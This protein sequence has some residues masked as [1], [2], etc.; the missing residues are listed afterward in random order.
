MVQQMSLG[1]DFVL[2]NLQGLAIC[3]AL[4]KDLDY[5]K[6]ESR[7]FGRI[8]GDVNELILGHN[9]RS[10][11]FA[12]GICILHAP[13]NKFDE[14]LCDRLMELME[15]LP[16]LRWVDDSASSK[17][18]KV[19][20]YE[21][22][23]FCLNTILGD[24]AA[25][26]FGL[27]DRIIDHQLTLLEELVEDITEF[28]DGIQRSPSLNQSRFNRRLSSEVDCMRVIS[29]IFGLVR[30][31]GRF[32]GDPKAPLISNIYPPPFKIQSEDDQNGGK[33]KNVTLSTDATNWFWNEEKES[34]KGGS[35]KVFS[36]H[37][38]SFLTPNVGDNDK[39]VLRLMFPEIERLTVQLKTLMDQKLLNTLDRYAEDVFHNQK[40]KRFPYK[41]VSETITLVSVTCL[42][43]VLQLYEM[44]HPD[45]PIPM[46]YAK[47]LYTF[48]A[49]QFAQ[50]Q[51]QLKMKN[52]NEDIREIR[53]SVDDEMTQPMVNRLK[54]LII[55]N[56]L[57]I[58]LIVWS[59]IDEN[60]GYL[61]CNNIQDKLWQP[62]RHVLIQNP[63]SVVA[64]EALG[65]MAEKFP[66]LS[67]TIV[68]RCL[69]SFLL[70]PCPLLTK[71]TSSE[72]D[73]GDRTMT[74]EQC[75]AVSRRR[76]GLNSLRTAAIDAL[77]RALKAA[78]PG[79]ESDSENG[80]EETL[81][82]SCLT[83][84]SAKLYV[85][86]NAAVE[87]AVYL[88]SENVIMALGSIGITLKDRKIPQIVLQ[89]F[90][91]RFAQPPSSLDQVIINSLADMWIAGATVIH[92]G[93][94]K[95]FTRIILESSN[96]V[97]TSDPLQQGQRYS[98]VSL[99]VDS[100][101]ARMAKALTK[102]EE[103]MELLYRLLELF[104]QLAI[105]GKRV[106]EKIRKTAVK[107]TANAGNLGVLIPKIAAL[108]VRMKPITEPTIKVKN[109][110]RDFFFYCS[111]VGFNL[112]VNDGLW[113]D[114]WYKALCQV[115]VKAPVL[116]VMENL[117]SEMIENAAIKM[118][119]LP[120]SDVQERRN[121]VMK[122][123]PQTPE[124]TT[125]ISRLDYAQCTYLLSVCRTE[126]MRVITS[127]EP[128]AP[129]QMFRYLEDKA[130]RK[131][132]SGIWSCLLA[133][134]PLIFTEYLN[135]MSKSNACR[136]RTADIRVT[137]EFLLI[138]FN[139]SIREV[140]RCADNCLTKLMDTFPYLLWNGQV[141]ATALSLIQAMS[142]IIEED[143]ECR[144]ATLDTPGF[145]W[146]LQLQDTLS[147]RESIAKDF[148]QRVEQILCEAMKWAPGT[149]HGHLLEYV[150]RT[151]STNN[152]SL[153]LTIDA[154]LHHHSTGLGSD[155]TPSTTD[156]NSVN[157]TALPKENT[158]LDVSAYLTSLNQRANYLG[159]IQGMLSMLKSTQHD[160]NLAQELLVEHLD[161]KFRDIFEQK[162]N[163]Y[164]DSNLEEDLEEAI[165]L[166]S[167][168]F[169]ESKNFEAKSLHN[170][171]WVPEKNFTEKTLE[172]C[173]SC[174]N[175][176]LVARED[177]Q[178]HF[179]QEMSGCF[180]QIA[181][182]GL[183]LFDRT[184]D[185]VECPMS[186]SECHRRKAPF[187]K[188]HAV[189]AGFLAERMSLAR[190]CNQEQIDLFEILFSRIL[191]LE[192]G[193]DQKGGNAQKIPMMSRHI[194][195]VGVRFRLLAAALTMI[196][197][198]FLTNSQSK[199][200]LRQRIYSAAFDYFTL[201]PQTPTMSSNELKEVIKYLIAFWKALNVDVKYIKKEAFAG[202][203]IASANLP[204]PPPEPQITAVTV[205]QQ[206]AQQNR[207]NSFTWHAAPSNQ[208]ASNLSTN[209]F[210]APAQAR[211]GLSQRTNSTKNAAQHAK[212]Q[213]KQVRNLYRKRQL[214]MFLVS[215]EVD[216]L[217]AWL[218]PLGA[219]EQENSDPQIDNYIRT[220]LIDQQ[221][222]FR[223]MARFAW[224]ISPELAVHL[225][226]RLP[227]YPAVKNT[228]RELVRAQPEAVTHL[229]EALQLF[230]GDSTTIVESD[231]QK[232]S[233]VLTWVHCSPVMA[234]SLLCPKI[235]PPHPS[236]AQYAVNV[237]R[238]CPPDLLLLYIPQ[239]VQCMR[240]DSMGYVADLILWLANH[241][242][243]VAH[244]LLWNM[245]ANMYLDEDAKQ[246][247]PVLY[248][249]LNAI[250][251]KLISNL[252]GTAKRFYKAEFDLFE[253]ITR[254]SGQIKHFEKGESR[255]KACLKALA[256]VQ[257]EGVTYIPSNP[258][259]IIIDIDYSSATPMQSAAKAPF[260]A[261]FRMKQC[262]VDGVEE[263]AL[264]YYEKEMEAEER[265]D[266][267]PKAN[268]VRVDPHGFVKHDPL[269]IRKGAI[270]KVG[271]DCRQD[272]LALQMMRL[273]KNICDQSNVDVDFFPYRVVATNPGCGVIECVPNAKS[274]NEIGHQTAFTLFEYFVTSYGD[275]N[276]EKF[277]T[278][279]RNFVKS[280]AAYSVFSFLLQ[281]KDR[282]N[283]NIMI[284]KDGH[285]IHIDFG[286]M[287]ESSPG[288]NMGF[289]PDFKLSQEM[290]DIMGHNMEHP[291]FKH[292][293]SLC[294]RIFLAV[295]PYYQDF[296]ALVNQMLD[297]KLPCFRGKTIPLL[298]SRF[299]PE[300]NDKDAAK[301]M[302]G[303]I[304]NCCTNIRSKMYDQLQYIQNDIPY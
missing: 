80:A 129:Q 104:V 114:D 184:Y 110:F 293:S 242:Q 55:A 124:I 6:L 86:E 44:P 139:H 12:A 90:L 221:K 262:G 217:N 250:S 233:H 73:K 258:E 226:P 105:E 167:A 66:A 193:L 145:Q 83:Q 251:E 147:A 15:M 10:T 106:N 214:L 212:I 69:C 138:M 57:C 153:R 121:L 185:N 36:R 215:H 255:K 43:D 297:T 35:R 261:C 64:L 39:H 65:G 168:Y 18:D 161:S 116:T 190:Y 213:E 206:A 166:S 150:R 127:S 177:V 30:T 279:R 5:D 235:Y 171:V 143:R 189:W 79:T 178:I 37:G 197:N 4:A 224:E 7:L 156:V 59:A 187:V 132:K 117:K 71:L 134:T 237:L 27:R 247:D 173:I 257:V 131:D 263:L 144:V 99:V 101:L 227:A 125:I 267:R 175:W 216:R 103:Q 239:I 285:I 191:S 157:G 2:S 192:I 61:V 146:T 33:P 211:N 50:G 174:W 136:Q 137:A 48:A 260:L 84:L 271:D 246:K 194:E 149:T 294:V 47:D 204:K 100:A 3:S 243:L 17:L 284:N 200:I 126:K 20:I 176:I 292:F 162:E 252:A 158:T 248:E 165:M 25:Q 123:V 46:E 94:I 218:N 231:S 135:K 272:V 41:S 163:S 92:D 232:F 198:D 220:V 301:Y 270:F 72:F 78:I 244:Q 266:P 62:H 280:M 76:L 96:R 98:H 128:D 286:F 225:V 300:M 170:L 278:A 9:V 188:P 142:K 265:K 269:V 148:S 288:G 169:V 11:Y 207:G 219:P 273:M 236:T 241:S 205:L 164:N 223:D 299:V 140:R 298:R 49:Q 82:R 34:T 229:T 93:V 108:I 60:S 180:L 95:L 228:I 230:L 155:F 238:A 38:S 172:L 287:F 45:S 209:T 115:A 183:G 22:F 19:T 26:H 75:E 159:R 21:Q 276:S 53:R 254:I 268:L 119:S 264:S 85:P 88:I 120:L 154:V 240:W 122:E 24:I 283:G 28:V 40:L 97:Y 56:S 274:R 289:E 210:T 208:S 222:Q 8:P 196:Q 58:E 201:A 109:L 303:I 179:L 253:R 295:R 107:M 113:P 281:I 31:I 249:P 77:C 89:I 16:V 275:E 63:I 277:R 32:S 118:D 23:L 199:T 70:D 91:Q 130:I 296:I 87:S 182:K 68:V 42:R 133:A 102:E 111:G 181:Q 141:I 245:N 67:S 52:F 234:I 151:N 186:R 51:E 1:E 304:N 54:M 81:I 202:S 13:H 74:K 203:D 160:Y 290:V 152:R 195:A 302:L 29:M 291:A 256:E 14:P 259:C 112:E 282:H